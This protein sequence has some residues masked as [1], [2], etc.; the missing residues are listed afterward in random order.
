MNRLDIYPLRRIEEV[1]TKRINIVHNTQTVIFSRLKEKDA[2]TPIF[3]DI[4]CFLL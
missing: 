1:L 2:K 3:I 4:S